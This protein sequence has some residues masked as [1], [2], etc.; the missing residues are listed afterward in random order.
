MT[1]ICIYGAGAIGGFM[2][3]RLHEAGAEVS[4]I[5]RGPH[6]EAIQKTGLRLTYAGQDR[7]Y[8]LPATDNPEELG[9]HDY[10][11]IALKAHA[12]KHIVPSLQPLMDEKTGIVSAVNGV[13]WWYFYN[14]N[15]GTA[16]DNQPLSS[17]DPGAAI[18]N[19]L[20]PERAIG[21]VVYPACEIAEPGRILHLDGDRFSLGEP[22]GEASDRIKTLSELMIKGG[23]KAPQKRRIRDEIWIK[24]WGNCSFNPVSALTGASLDQIGADEGC[25]A[26]VYKIMQECQAVG[27]ALGVRFAVSIEERI[28]GAAR[29]IGH[30]PSTRQDIEA[31]RPLEID[32]LM[33]AVL[34]LANGLS[35]PTPALRQVTSLLKLQASTLG[36]YQSH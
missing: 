26:L 1:K 2:A 32:P 8:Q 23:L 15:T 14:A 19:G 18:W 16:F 12:L 7:V 4:L 3:A 9:P 36:L 25:R 33:T 28:E 34:E 22:S 6:L 17:V 13:P 29:I 27:E 11:I 31:G 20:G 35:I 24:L 5:A 30:K 10:I 21:C